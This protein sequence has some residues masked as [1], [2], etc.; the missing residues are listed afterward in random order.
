[1]TSHTWEGPIWGG[2]SHGSLGSP[3]RQTGKECPRFLAF[4]GCTGFS[5]VIESS[6]EVRQPGRRAW[7]SG[8]D[9]SHQARECLTMP[10]QWQPAGATGL[11]LLSPTA[12]PSPA[13]PPCTCGLPPLD[14]KPFESARL[15]SECPLHS[16]WHRAGVCLW[17]EARDSGRRYSTQE[18]AHSE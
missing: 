10:S 17:E 12:K 7:K 8:Q 18:P 1:M 13:S 16:A 11:D 9:T 3:Q 5:L 4:S 14:R 15:A 2:E 6:E